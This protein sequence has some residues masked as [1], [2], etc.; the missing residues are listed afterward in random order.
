MSDPN[1][2]DE[3][4]D[5]WSA[6]SSAI[7]DDAYRPPPKANTRGL[8]PQPPPDDP[9][10]DAILWWILACCAVGLALG[11]TVWFAHGGE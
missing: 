8:K 3:P 4:I 11:V 10:H 5:P 9:R 7:I 1:K 6:E 2:P